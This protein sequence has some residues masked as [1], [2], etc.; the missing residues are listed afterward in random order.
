MT[1]DSGRVRSQRRRR[2][3]PFSS[4]LVR[5]SLGE[6]AVVGAAVLATLLFVGDAW[7]Q[8]ETFEP[9]PDYRIPF[10]LSDDYWLFHR[11]CAQAVRERGRDQV[12]V[13]GDSFVWGQFVPAGQTL[14]H[15]LNQEAGSSRFVNLG[16][17]GAH[18]LAVEGLI[19]HHCPVMRYTQVLVHLNFLW[20]SSPQADLQASG[21][22]RVNHP[23]LLPQLTRPIPSYH[24]SIPERIGVLVT[25]TL[26][27]FSWSRH[28]QIAYLDHTDLAG[29]TLGHPYD[30]PLKEVT[31][32]LPDP[33]AARYPDPQ[34][35]SAEGETRQ[36]LPWVALEG[37]LQWEAFQR[38]IRELRSRGNR[39]R[40]LVGPL[41]QHM[42]TES[43]AEEY[44]HLLEEA[45][46]WLRSE[47]V[48][49]FALTTL[50]S[51]RYADLS[52][53]LHPGYA[54]LAGELWRAMSRQ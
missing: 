2:L 29:W 33:S 48:P 17:D 28:L 37:S 9:G 40:V 38:T 22:V 30:N 8:V 31:L 14:T 7:R 35:W 10:D 11:Y 6:W 47:G 42:L 4:N 21:E 41:N 13:L 5:L 23:R 25:R 3:E 27:S 1:E 12:L 43:S 34:P 15:F 50:P 49:V 52:H 51:E 16:L 44:R 18:P 53:P 46:A 20:M 54:T 26:P 36:D 19:R 39:V 45:L 32:E 24:A